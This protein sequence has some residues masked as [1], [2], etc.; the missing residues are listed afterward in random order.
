MASRGF[1]ELVRLTDLAKARQTGRNAPE[2]E[3]WLGI[4]FELAGQRLVAPLGEVSE[5]LAYPELTTMPL[6][7]PWML[8]V[9]NVRGRLL[10]LTDLAQFLG[11][12]SEKRLKSRKVLVIDQEEVFTGLLVDQVF[13]IGRFS[14]AQYIAE[15]P[16]SMS[17]FAP[18]HHGKFSKDGIEYLVFMPSLLMEDERY[19]NAASA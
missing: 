1:I 13:G 16:D 9:A 10:P 5:V 11:L 7:K 6:T 17:A 14:E 2:R 15:E 19:L 18:Y 4:M 8:G 3:N 12:H